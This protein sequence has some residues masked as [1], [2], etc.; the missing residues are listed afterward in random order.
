[1]K[2]LNEAIK[3]VKKNATAKFDEAIEVHFNF[4]LDVTKANQT[5]RTT[6]ALPHGTGK[7]TKVAVL[8]S[9][10]VE[11]ADLNLTKADINKIDSGDISAGNDFDILITEPKYMSD[12]AKLGPVL[13]PI[14]LM[15]NPKNGT[16][17]DDV[18]KAVESFK[19]GK[20][21]LRNEPNAPLIHAVIGKVSFSNKNLKENFMEIFNTIKS[22][23]P[24]KAK[25]DWIKNC[26]ITSTMGNS[27]E[28]DIHNL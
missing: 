15:P 28:I 13:G 23:K 8:S 2:S 17:T 7:K 9:K 14:G 3:T 6:T 20:I 24:V 16:I 18:E 4:K 19:S 27:I 5:V 10:K 22:S 11:N 12:L 26:F 21:E 1:M 25:P